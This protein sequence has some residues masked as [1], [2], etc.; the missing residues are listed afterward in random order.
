MTLEAIDDR[1]VAFEYADD[2]PR[3]LL[4]T[5][6]LAVVGPRNDILALAEKKISQKIMFEVKKEFLLHTGSPDTR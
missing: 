2:V 1:L 6:E 3:L 5:E 4:P